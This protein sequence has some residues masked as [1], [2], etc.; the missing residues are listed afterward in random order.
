M[1]AAAHLEQDVLADGVAEVLRHR[2]AERVRRLVAVVPG[3]DAERAARS[4]RRSATAS[5]ATSAQAVTSSCE[6]RATAPIA[7][8]TP[9]ERRRRS[10]RP[11]GRRGSPPP[12]RPGP[13]PV[14]TVSPLG[15]EVVAEVAP[16]RRTPGRRAQRVAAHHP[17][18]RDGRWV[19]SSSASSIE[20][21]VQRLR[22]AGGAGRGPSPLGRDQA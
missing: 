2:R 13:P 20:L 5:S 15:G 22:P 3:R 1:P 6:G 12:S 21:V 4:R 9:L 19:N 11:A 8:S 14:A 7:S 17:D 16:R 10:R 18:D